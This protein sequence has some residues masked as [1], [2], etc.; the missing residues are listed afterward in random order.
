MSARYNSQNKISYLSSIAM[1]LHILRVFKYFVFSNS[2]FNCVIHLLCFI[3]SFLIALFYF[4]LFYLSQ[5][6]CPWL[7]IYVAKMF[8]A[9][10]L[11]AKM[12]MAK[13][14]TA[15]IPIT[16]MFCDEEASK[17]DGFDTK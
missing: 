15:K 17:L 2:L 8:A 11:V 10:M 7:F 3:M 14:L 9:K 13:T 6:N 12:F 16:F 5:Q 4:S 1:I